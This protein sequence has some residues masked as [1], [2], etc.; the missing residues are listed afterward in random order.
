M[1]IDRQG[2]YIMRKLKRRRKQT[3]RSTRQIKRRCKPWNYTYDYDNK[4]FQKYFR[5]RTGIHI[6]DEDNIELSR[7]L[8]MSPKADH[9]LTT[10][11][12]Y[13][14]ANGLKIPLDSLER[15]NAVAWHRLL[16]DNLQKHWNDFIKI[17]RKI[18]RRK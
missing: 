15:P 14:Y 13:K 6:G 18:R 16:R 12:D 1:A 3:T 8:L 17:P 2:F 7:F 11:K 9:W 4:R 10:S 5:E